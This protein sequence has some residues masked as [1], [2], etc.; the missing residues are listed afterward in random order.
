MSTSEHSLFRSDRPA[1][2]QLFKILTVRFHLFANQ[3][4]RNEQDADEIAQEALAVIAREYGHLDIRQS[5][6]AWAYKVLQNRIL[7]YVRSPSSRGNREIR[8]DESG[9]TAA[10][11]HPD[12]GLKGRLLDCLEEVTRAKRRYA[13]VLNL[14]YQ[15]YSTEEICSRLGLTANNSYVLLSRARAMLKTCLEQGDDQL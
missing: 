13:R 6:A 9:D 4:I 7:S 14:H 5:F 11:V 3:G 10:S 15:G 12:P 2:N 8:L 1:K